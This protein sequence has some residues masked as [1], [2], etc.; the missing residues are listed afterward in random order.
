MTAW[1]K[2]R[3]LLLSLL[4]LAGPCPFAPT[5]L[6]P[7]APVAS[8]DEEEQH[9]FPTELA[10]ALDGAQHAR[11]PSERSDP[12]E[13]A[14]APHPPRRHHAPAVRSLTPPA[15]FRTTVNSPLHC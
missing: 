12:S 4:L 9:S 8:Q 3:L 1:R 14:L 6:L 5:P 13:E 10:L 2:I 11:R 7:L 15:P